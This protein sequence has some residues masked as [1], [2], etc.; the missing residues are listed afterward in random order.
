MIGSADLMPRN[1]DRRVEVIAP[2][3]ALDHQHQLHE[4]LELN[5]ADDRLAW[6]LGADAIWR[7]VPTVRDVDAQRRLYELAQLRA[8]RGLDRD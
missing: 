6:E 8:R 2:V 4:V 7:K 5:L 3:P 1:L